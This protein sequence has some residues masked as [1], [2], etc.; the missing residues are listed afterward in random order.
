[1]KARHPDLAESKFAWGGSFGTQKGGGGVSDLM[2]F[3]IMRR[4]GGVRRIISR[5]SMG[6][7]P[8][9]NRTLKNYLHPADS[10]PHNKASGDAARSRLLNRKGR[11]HESHAM[12]HHPAT[13]G[14]ADHETVVDTS[15][16][17]GSFVTTG[18]A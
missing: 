6:P 7:M 8:L 12:G 14:K 18:S 13:M 3:D 9:E 15:H 17:A 1:M 2:H 11:Q 16:M 5:R 4:R 10:H